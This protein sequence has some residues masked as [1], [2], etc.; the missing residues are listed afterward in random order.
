MITYFDGL[1]WME[2]YNGVKSESVQNRV[3]YA[4]SVD[5]VTWTVRCAAVMRRVCVHACHRP[6]FACLR[7]P[8]LPEQA[9][10]STATGRHV[11]HDGPDRT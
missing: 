8:C 4:T 6:V 9:T 10:L 2:W 7:A 11:Q 3:L 1:Y 5:A